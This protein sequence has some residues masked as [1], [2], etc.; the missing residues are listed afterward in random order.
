MYF[1]VLSIHPFHPL[2]M[3]TGP[4]RAADLLDAGLAPSSNPGFE[5]GC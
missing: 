5:R 4:R 1:G 3:S 2:P